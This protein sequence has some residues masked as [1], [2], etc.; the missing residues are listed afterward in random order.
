[1]KDI[2]QIAHKEDGVKESKGKANNPRILK[3]A[4]D[5]GFKNYKG[6][7]QAW[8]SLFMNWCAH[9]AGLERSYS[10]KARSWLDVG[11]EITDPE[12]GDVVIFWRESPKSWKGHVG[13]FDGFRRNGSI[14]CLGGNQGNQVSKSAQSADRLLGFRRLR[15]ARE[16]RFPRTALKLKSTGNNVRLLQD[17]LKKLG[18]EVGTSDGVFGSRTKETLMKFQASSDQMEVNGIF[19]KATRE[20]MTTAI[21]AIVTVKELADKIFN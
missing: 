3:Y 16:V 13:M 19:D 10:L 17:S 18:Y 8:C 6:D 20:C 4:E 5:I 9:K 12:P 1:M 15:P 7:D 14:Y 21:N 2:V 11:I